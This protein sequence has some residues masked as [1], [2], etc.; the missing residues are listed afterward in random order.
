MN[1]W[2]TSLTPDPRKPRTVN[3]RTGQ[4]PLGKGVSNQAPLCK[5]K[6]CTVFSL[7]PYQFLRDKARRQGPSGGK[8][9]PLIVER[10]VLVHSTECLILS[11]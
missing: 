9:A 10:M 8:K 7:H 5:G 3:G 1:T 4:C 6:S 2:I 11:A